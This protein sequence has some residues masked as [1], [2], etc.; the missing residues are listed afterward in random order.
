M[1]KGGICGTLATTH[2]EGLLMLSHPVQDQQVG[3][4]QS[5]HE[6]AYVDFGHRLLHILLLGST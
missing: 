2:L 4:I 5:H 3:T 1:S 6:H